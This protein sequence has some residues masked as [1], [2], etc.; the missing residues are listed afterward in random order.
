MQFAEVQSTVII[1]VPLSGTEA[2]AHGSVHT[3]EST[4]DILSQQ[5]VVSCSVVC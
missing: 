4:D 1:S 3:N 5:T 2:A